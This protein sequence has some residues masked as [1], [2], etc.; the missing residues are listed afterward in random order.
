M[1]SFNDSLMR[2]EGGRHAS[3]DPAL[4][5]EIAAVSHLLA[6]ID[7][8]ESSLISGPLRVDRQHWV[9]IAE[10]DALP[11]AVLVPPSAAYFSVI[12]EAA[13]PIAAVQPK[14]M[15]LYTSTAISGGMSMWREYLESYRDSTLYRDSMLFPL[16]WDTWEMQVDREDLRI[17]E[18]VS[19]S[20]WVEFVEAHVFVSDGLVYPDWEKI[21]REFDA[22][23][24]TLPAIVAAQGFYFHTRHGLMVPAFWNVETTFW[25]RWCFTEARLVETVNK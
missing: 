14:T 6:K 23:H 4:A 25:L 1:E 3:I 13:D 7:A 22:I 9:A 24:I 5:D 19:A 8:R 10:R 21:A 15:G 17:A 20:R 16:P 12:A 11:D 2:I 18:I